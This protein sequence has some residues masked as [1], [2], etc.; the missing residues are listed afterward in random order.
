MQSIVNS[1]INP[2]AFKSNEELLNEKL[3][4]KEIKIVRLARKRL[5]ELVSSLDHKRA[6][7]AHME[8]TN[9]STEIKKLIPN[10]YKNCFMYDVLIQGSAERGTHSFFDL[11]TSPTIAETIES[12]HKRYFPNGSN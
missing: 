4:E 3:S 7:E 5:S 8:R 2:E 1:K 11:E 12:Q 6:I 10:D 9:Y